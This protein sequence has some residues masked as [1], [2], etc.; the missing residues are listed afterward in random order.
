MDSL[1]LV[2]VSIVSQT[3]VCAE[4]SRLLNKVDCSGGKAR[5]EVCD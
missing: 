1:A 2:D 3:D 4:G 5:I